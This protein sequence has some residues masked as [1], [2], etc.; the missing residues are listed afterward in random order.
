MNKIF[1]FIIL[2]SLP[3]IA[4]SC[5]KENNGTEPTPPTPPEPK[6]VEKIEIKINP[7]VKDTRATDF[8]FESGD[9]IGIY[10]VNYSGT[11]PGSLK[12][13]GNHVDNM[14]FTYSG[15]WTPTTPIYWLDNNTH[16]DF[17]LYYPFISSIESIDALPFELKNDQSLEANYKAC[18]F[19]MGKTSDIAPTE[20]AVTIGADHLMSR[21]VISLE[22]GNGFTK[23]SLAAANIQVKI[24]GIRTQS[25]INIAN[26]TVI[27]SGE[28]TS[29]TPF[30]DNSA[31]KALIV[32]QK[33]EECNLISV[34][35][36]GREFNL[37]KGFTFESGKSHN[38][39]VTLSKTSNGINVN[40]NPWDEDD[41]DNGGTAE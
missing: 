2:L 39:T 20:T 24:N 5:G 10:V 14:C 16:A 29:I 31:Y 32:P 37:K 35:V 7:A 27:A 19:M 28:P 11:T 22:A 40:I 25:L 8:G 30:K 1:A 4:I 23:E 3:I 34:T 6:P 26:A 36:D 33:V 18:D 21:M 9:K 41:T 15:T 13:T 38:F 12:N 17:Y